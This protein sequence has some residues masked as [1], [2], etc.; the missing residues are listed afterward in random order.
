MEM[1]AVASRHSRKPQASKAVDRRNVGHIRPVS[2]G[3]YTD[4]PDTKVFL[5]HI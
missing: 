1:V 4:D 3:A 5:G 2:I